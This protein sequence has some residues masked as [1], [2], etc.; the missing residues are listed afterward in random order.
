MQP[1]CFVLERF[2]MI[3]LS[4]QSASAVSHYFVR[5]KLHLARSTPLRK[6][7]FYTESYWRG[8]I[9]RYREAREAGLE[10]RWFMCDGPLIIGHVGFDQVV[11]GAFQSC[12]LGYGIDA[13]KQGQGLMREA[14]IKPL[15][16]ILGD[17]GLNRVMAN[18]EPSNVRSGRLLKSLGFERE[19]Y[20]RK[21]LK[22]NGRWRDHILTSLVADKSLAGL[23][24]NDSKSNNST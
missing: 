12:Y 7:G 6:E 9:I 5:N 21:Y 16:Y 2:S 20:A 10:Y 11:Q 23:N 22:L 14:L 18:Y 3:E 8:Q 24:R 1:V 17:V 19:G 4:E 13:D 15:E